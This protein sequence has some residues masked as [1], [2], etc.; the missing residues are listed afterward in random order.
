MKA[1]IGISKLGSHAGQG[2]IRISISDDA[3]GLLVTEVELSLAD[4]MECLTGLHGTRAEFKFIPSDYATARYGKKKVIDHV[5]MEVGE[6]RCFDKQLLK[7]TVEEHFNLNYHDKGW[8]IWDDGTR[9]QQ[10]SRGEHKYTICK[11]IEAED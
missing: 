6:K 11:Y 8:E 5:S 1:R 4:M 9:L 2:V 3:S 7:S 10:N